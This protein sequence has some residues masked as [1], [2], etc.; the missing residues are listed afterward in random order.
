MPSDGEEENGESSASQP[1]RDDG[2]IA[3][4]PQTKSRGKIMD[5]GGTGEKSSYGE[6]KNDSAKTDEEKNGD[7]RTN[8]GKPKIDTV[9]VGIRQ[10][11]NEPL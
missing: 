7:R 9:I 5:K 3:A 6:G 8:N 4:A 10:S 1:K 11:R 2:N